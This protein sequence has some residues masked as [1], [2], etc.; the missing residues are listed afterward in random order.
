MERSIHSID[1][2]L[3]KTSATCNWLPNVTMSPM[4][5]PN[6]EHVCEN[7]DWEPSIQDSFTSVCGGSLTTDIYRTLLVLTV[8]SVNFCP[9]GCEICLMSLAL[10]RQIKVCSYRMKTDHK[11]DQWR[12]P[13]IP[14]LCTFKDV[15]STD[16]YVL[17]NF[18]ILTLGTSLTSDLHFS[19]SSC[20]I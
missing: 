5:K 15:S 18:Y 6:I 16:A 4:C 9:H 17:C 13:V 7:Y 20:H 1:Y 2:S 12:V 8:N 11:I 14:I 10:S 3:P 19:I